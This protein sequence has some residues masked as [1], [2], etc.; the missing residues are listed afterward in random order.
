MILSISI[1]LDRAIVKKRIFICFWVIQSCSFTTHSSMNG[2]MSINAGPVWYQAGKT[3]NLA[4]YDDFSDEYVAGNTNAPLISGELFLGLQHTITHHFFGQWGVAFS[5]ATSAIPHGEIWETA[6]PE[7]N[8][9]TYQYKIDHNQISLKGLLLSAPFYDVYQPYLGG[10]VGV[11]FNK[12]FHFSQTPKTFEVVSSANFQSYQQTAFAYTLS[13]GFRRY[14]TKHWQIGV[15]YEFGDWGKSAL[16]E[17]VDQIKTGAISLNHLYTNQLQI[18]VTYLL[19][20][21][22]V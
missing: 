4:V 16:S 11:S 22:T 17:S 3:Q 15:G 6:D 2:V 1:D 7:F 9:F 12:S 21:E 18:N 20:E 5:M 14:M 8:N 10:S 13:A 19:N